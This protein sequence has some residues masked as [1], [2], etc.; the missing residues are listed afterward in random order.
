MDWLK[1]IRNLVAHSKVPNHGYTGTM[2]S[3]QVILDL[4]NDENLAQTLLAV[5]MERI[6]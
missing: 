4:G 6:L 3:L 1:K 5:E 2:L